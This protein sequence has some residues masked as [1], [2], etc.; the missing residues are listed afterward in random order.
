MVNGPF[1]LSLLP[2]QGVFSK[3]KFKYHTNATSVAMGNR[4]IILSLLS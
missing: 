3:D 4:M 2:D 1:K